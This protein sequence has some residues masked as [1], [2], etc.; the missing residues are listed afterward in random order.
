[1]EQISEIL[2]IFKFW[3]QSNTRTLAEMLKID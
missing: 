1:M 2:V 3:P